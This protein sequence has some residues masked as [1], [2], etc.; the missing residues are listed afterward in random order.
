MKLIQLMK[1]KVNNFFLLKDIGN[2]NKKEFEEV[3]FETLNTYQMEP[4]KLSFNL[5]SMIF[6]VNLEIIYFD[7]ILN[8][9]FKNEKIKCSKIK[10]NFNS[11]H[12]APTITLMYNFISFGKYYTS[13]FYENHKNILQN[14]YSNIC[15]KISIDSLYLCEKCGKNT[16]KI[17]FKNYE[18]SCCYDCLKNYLDIIIF[19]RVKFYEIENFISRECKENFLKNFH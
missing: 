8:Q 10:F 9:S 2:K 4:F 15:K 11:I 14:S 6:N 18:Y 3:N 7:T 17:N 13:K 5:A 12:E 1:I 19:D 16:K